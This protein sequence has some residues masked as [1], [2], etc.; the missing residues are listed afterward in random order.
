RH[1]PPHRVGL[2]LRPRQPAIDR[3][4]KLLREHELGG[5]QR[6]LEHAV[7]PAVVAGVEQ[8]RPLVVQPSQ[9]V[10]DLPVGGGAWDRCLALGGGGALGDSFGCT[11]S[12]AFAVSSFSLSASYESFTFA[13][14]S[15]LSDV[16]SNQPR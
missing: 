5:D 15:V 11:F 1:R 6:P 7:A 12:L 8:G 16:A 9:Q 13:L 4:L 10:D 2:H 3:L 14:G